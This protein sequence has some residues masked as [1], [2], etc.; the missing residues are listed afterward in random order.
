LDSLK[1]TTNTKL[2]ALLTGPPKEKFHL[3]RTK[4]AADHA[5]L[6]LLPVSLNLSSSSRDNPSVSQNNNLLIAPDL[7]ETRAATEDGLTA[8]FLMPLKTDGL[9]LLN[10]PMLPRTRVA[11]RKE[12]TSRSLVKK[13]SLDA[14]DSATELT[15]H[16]FL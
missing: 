4:V 8:P 2:L 6:S 15:P 14:L 10:I 7:K 9:Q 1:E 11:S 16:Q 5:G 13:A 3:S 12:V